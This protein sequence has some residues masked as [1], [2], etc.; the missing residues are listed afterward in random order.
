METRT[1]INLYQ[2]QGFTVTRI[3]GDQEFACITNDILPTP[4]NIADADDH[5]PH[6]ERSIRTVKERTRCLI[7]GLPFKRIPIAMMRSAVENSHKVLN[8]FPARDGASKTLSPLTIMTGKPSPDYNGMKIEFGACPQVFEDKDPTNTM[9]ARTSGAIVLTPTGNA[10]GGYYFL[11]L[12]ATGRKLYRQQW[13]E[14]PMPNGVIAT[15]ER[16]ALAEQ[17]PL[18]G[19]GAPL[20]EWAPGVEIMDKLNAPVPQDEPNDVEIAQ[21][22]PQ[23]APQGAAEDIMFGQEPDGVHIK[24]DDDSISV[25]EQ[26]EENEQNEERGSDEENDADVP[27]EVEPEAEPEDESESEVEDHVVVEEPNQQPLRCSL[28]TNRGR[29]YSHRLDHIMDDPENSKSYDTQFLQQTDQG[30]PTLRESVQEMQKTG[31]KTEVLKYITG[32]IMTQM[33]ANAGIKKHGQV[34]IDALFQEFSQ[35]HDLGV[36]EGQDARK[37]TDAQKRAALRAISM[38]KK[39]RC[40]KIKGRAVADGRSQRNLFT[41]EQTTSPTVSTDALMLSILIDALERRDVATADVAGAYLHAHMKDFTLLKVEGPSVDKL[42]DVS[43]EYKKFVCYEDGKKVL[44]LKLL[45]ALYGCVQ[46]ALLWYELFSGTLKNMG[47]K[48]NPY[49][50]C[51]ANKTINDKQCTIV[52][53][54]DDTKISHVDSIVVTK[55]I[56]A[57][58]EKFG[59]MTVTRGKS[60][61]SL[62]MDIDS[63]QTP[64]PP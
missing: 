20:F 9:K 48:L 24:D 40:G 47:F 23:G 60:H 13:N 59:D 22:A 58:E 36:F 53:Y 1:I 51:V 25:A 54:V 42:C 57:I 33:T 49:D 2:T 7:Q 12:L 32:F 55:I 31:S 34:A 18:A 21:G 45:K 39:K 35:L 8:Q 30:A 62:G 11:S 28:R 64:Q 38:I 46:S 10:Q 15:V 41:K 6:V 50:T 43:P 17:Q 52:W 27:D 14:L 56:K 37:L 3:E 63:T 29:N 5:V 26:Q 4:T 61:V 16:M 19:H 44:Y